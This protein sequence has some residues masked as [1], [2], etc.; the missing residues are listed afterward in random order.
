MRRAAL[1][2]SRA[3]RVWRE[4]NRIVHN[5]LDT[6]CICDQQPNRFRKGQKR[7]GC[8]KPRCYLC[9]GEKLLDL[10]TYQDKIADEKFS[11]ELEEISDLLS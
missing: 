2:R 10:P 8:G 4:H 6:G 11:Y 7:G 3:L 1:E 9:H 5:G